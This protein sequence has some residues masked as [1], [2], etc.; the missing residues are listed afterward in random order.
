MIGRILKIGLI[1]VAGY[2]GFTYFF[3]NAEEKAQS[4]E[5]VGDIGQAGKKIFGKIGVMLNKQKDNFDEGKHDE[6]LAKVGEELDKLKQ[7]AKDDR[8]LERAIDRLEIEKDKIAEKI[9][10]ASPEEKKNLKD[11]FKNL[12]DKT[13]EVL[14]NMEDKKE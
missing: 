6:A 12:V 5:I 2:L 11:R 7:K 3:G 13:Q 9:Q 14:Q 10:N 1:L 8:I 4:R